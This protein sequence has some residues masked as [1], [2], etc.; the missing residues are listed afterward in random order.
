METLLFIF[1][2]LVPIPS[3]TPLQTVSMDTQHTTKLDAKLSIF[4]TYCRTDSLRVKLSHFQWEIVCHGRKPIQTET[5]QILVL[6][7]IGGMTTG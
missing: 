5:D 4:D 7:F 1:F 2:V 3:P 6:L